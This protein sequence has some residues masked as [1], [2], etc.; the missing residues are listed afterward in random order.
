[1][2]ISDWSSD[3]CSSDLREFW[4][5]AFTT[6]SVIATFAQ[7]I[8]LG[9]LLQ[10]ITVEGRAYAGGWWEWLTPFSLLTGLGLLIGY[11]LLGACWLNWKTEAG[12]QRQAVTYAGRLGIALLLL[13]GAVRLATL[14]L[15]GQ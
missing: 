8:A 2:L 3:G 12:L 6:G 9:A 14:S 1:M 11:A 4:D 10:G 5:R 13:F 15:V 7:G